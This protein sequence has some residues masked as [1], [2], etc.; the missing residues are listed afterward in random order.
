M[1][2]PNSNLE[3]LGLDSRLQLKFILFTFIMMGHL[4][5]Y[6]E[7]FAIDEIDGTLNDIM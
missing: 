3:T 5:Y 4:L 7:I 6:N 1:I 2:I